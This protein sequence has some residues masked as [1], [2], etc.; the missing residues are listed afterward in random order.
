MKRLLD[1]KL[2]H[3]AVGSL[4]TLHPAPFDPLLAAQ[5]LTEG[6]ALVTSAARLA[7]FHAP[8]VRI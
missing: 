4:P 5:A 6:S 7:P 2:Q 8:I 1:A 3:W